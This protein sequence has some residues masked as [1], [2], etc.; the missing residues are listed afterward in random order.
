M[1]ARWL[2]KT[3]VARLSA[4]GPMKPVMRPDSANSPK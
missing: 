2:A 1:P 3:A 4:S